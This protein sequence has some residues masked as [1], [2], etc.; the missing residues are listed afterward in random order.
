[1]WSVAR[2][3]RT[4]LRCPRA[5]RSARTCGP[6]CTWSSGTCSLPASCSSWTRHRRY[7]LH[8]RR[9]RLRRR[10]PRGRERRTLS[11]CPPW[12]SDRGRRRV[13]VM[14]PQEEEMARRGRRRRQK[15]APAKEGTTGTPSGVAAHPEEGGERG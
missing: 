15:L 8:R 5:T 10:C 14:P 6:S 13:V 2:G 9:R 11:F 12:R 3:P 4:R 1:R 7:R